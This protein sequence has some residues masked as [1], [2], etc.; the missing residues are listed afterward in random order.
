ML[1]AEDV[2]I[3]LLDLLRRDLPGVH[4]V[5]LRG[6]IA[7]G[8]IRVNGEVCLRDCRLRPVDVVEVLREPSPRPAARQAAPTLPRVLHET[9]STLVVAKPAGMPTVPDRTG[10]DR[11]VHGLLPMLRPDADLRIVHRLD[12]DTSGCLVLAKGLAAA[13]HFDEQFRLGRVQKTYAA[14]VHGVVHREQFAIDDWLGPDPRRPGKVVASPREHDGFR[15]AHTEVHR[16]QAHAHF[17]LLSLRPTTGRSHQLRVH[18]Q[19]VG[20]AIVGDLDYGGEMLLLSRLK[21]GYKSKK[22]VAERPLLARMFLHAEHIV[23]TDPDGAEVRVE[24]PWPDDLMT[25]YER[26]MAFDEPRRRACD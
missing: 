2:G 3:Q 20:H 9:A 1:E 17:T 22:G 24:A 12:R 15:E 21:P 6:A 7:A 19:A 10:V 8:D 11:G 16:R 4:L 14:L 13:R 23:F 26:V 18:L 25:A 5:D